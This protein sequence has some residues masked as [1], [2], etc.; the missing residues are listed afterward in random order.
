M[1]EPL[2]GRLH[3]FAIV[4]MARRAIG[5]SIIPLVVVVFTFRGGALIPALA[6]LLVAF[7]V[8][9]FLQWRRFSYTVTDDRLV[10]ERG[11]LNRT[12]RVVPLDR[13]RG[14]DVTAPALHRVLGL[15][16]VDVEAAAGGSSRAELTLPAVAREDAELLRARVLARAVARVDEAEGEE[17]RPAPRPIFHASP[18]LLAVGGVTSGRYVLAP[19]AV[20]GVVANLAD[21]LPGG[22]VDRVVDAVVD[23]IPRSVVAAAVLAVVALLAAFALAAA[24]SLLVDWEFTLTDDGERIVATRGLLTHR[25][26]SIERAR[27][28]GVDVVDTPLRRPFHLA[29]VQVVASGIQG[30]QGGR[31]TL[32]P[33]AR[34]GAVERL[35]RALDPRDPSLAALLESHPRSARSRRLVRAVSLPA[36]AAAVAAGLGEWT[37]AATLAAVS[38]ACVPLGLDRYRQLGHHYDGDRLV[39]REGSLRRRRTTLDP[40]AVV[41]WDLRRSPAQARRELSTVILH[42]GQGAGSRRVLDC[43]DEQAAELLAALDPP[44]LGPLVARPAAAAGQTM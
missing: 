12:T 37:T 39:V 11:L 28:R 4:V 40:R 24:G 2:V 18:R 30:G 16:Q 41:A 5:T 36:A 19:L 14:V 44:L 25:S 42:L 1:T 26:V 7:A 31:Q 35:G 10:I 33:V 17:E 21:D 8:V 9:L 15:V 22:G 29:A 20:I 43:S 38:L 6:A 3:P 13:I 23:L 27:I 32:A 34:L